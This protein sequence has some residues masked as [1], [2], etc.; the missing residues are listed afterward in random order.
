MKGLNKV[1]LIGTMGKDVDMRYTQS[2]TAIAS[3]SL[4]TNETWK[5]KQ[6]GEKREAT[7]WHNISIFGKLAELAGQFLGKGS[8]IYLEGKIKTEKYQDSQTGQDKYST[9]IIADNL[10]MLG[11]GNNQGQNQGQPMPPQQN[12]AP[13]QQYQAP[14]NQPPAQQQR[15]QQ[16]RPQQPPPPPYA[17]NDFDDDVPF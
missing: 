4:A 3:F 6:T 12:Y 11:G 5:D 2:G 17:P 1:T 14:V 9:K 8:N 10:I 16:Q 13:A 15:P 7:E